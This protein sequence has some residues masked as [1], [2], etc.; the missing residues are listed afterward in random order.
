MIFKGRR[1]EEA[2]WCHLYAVNTPECFTL[3]SA[4]VDGHMARPELPKCFLQR[5]RILRQMS[6]HGETSPGESRRSCCLN[7]GRWGAQAGDTEAPQ[8]R[9]WEGRLCNYEL[10]QQACLCI[11]TFS[12]GKPV[13]VLSV[14]IMQAKQQPQPLFIYFFKIFD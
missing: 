2:R 7:A 5:R 9:T 3:K 13:P 12:K 8:T 11:T 14:L 1:R 6:R 4:L 10:S